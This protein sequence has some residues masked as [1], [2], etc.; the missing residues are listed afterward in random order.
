MYNTC[1]SYEQEHLASEHPDHNA[2]TQPLEQPEERSYP[3]P[4]PA[5]PNPFEIAQAKARAEA[6]TKT[7]KGEVEGTYEAGIGMGQYVHL[8]DGRGVG[9]I[10]STHGQYNEIADIDFVTKN[11]VEKLKDVS[12]AE[13]VKANT[14]LKKNSNELPEVH[15]L[16]IEDI[17]NDENRLRNFLI[18]VGYFE[19]QNGQIYS[20]QE[21]LNA[22]NEARND[23]TNKGNNI[24][25]L[26]DHRINDIFSRLFGGKSII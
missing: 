25:Q 21:I 3:P 24:P 9:F 18:N 12:M 5:P 6:A 14:D 10:T 13:I 16:K 20:A 7:V 19:G 2:I 17:G 22:A 4:P 1:M 23:F 15:A 11:G 8:P 26:R